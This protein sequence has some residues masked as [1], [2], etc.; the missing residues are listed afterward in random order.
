[1]HPPSLF[2]DRKLMRVALL[3]LTFDFFLRLSEIH[4]FVFGDDTLSRAG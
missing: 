2:F 3:A 1:M 4:I